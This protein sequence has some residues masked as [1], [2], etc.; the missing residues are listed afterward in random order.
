[1]EYPYGIENSFCPL[2][3]LYHIFGD[4][5]FDS[6]NYYLQQQFVKLLLWIYLPLCNSFISKLLTHIPTCLW[7]YK[8]FYWLW[9]LFNADLINLPWGI[10]KQQT[11]QIRAYWF[12]LNDALAVSSLLYMVL[13]SFTLMH[14]YIWHNSFSLW[15][16]FFNNSCNLG[17]LMEFFCLKKSFFFVFILKNCLHRIQSYRVLG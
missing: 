7:S 11:S 8:C 10:S 12:V 3:A 5:S 4:F 2:F 14:I 15:R 1:M 17:L 9:R 13:H 6:H 16:T